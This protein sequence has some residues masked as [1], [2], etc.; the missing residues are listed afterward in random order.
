MRRLSSAWRQQGLKIALVPTMGFFHQGHLSLM[1][2]ARSLGE[3]VVVSLFVNPTQFGPGEDLDKYPRDIGRDMMLAEEH[4]V[5]CVFM[6]DASDIYYPK[7]QTWIEVTEVSKGLCGASRPGHFRG[8]ATVVAKLFNIVQPDLAI[9]GEKDYQQLQVIRTMVRDLNMPVE[10]KSHPTVREPD[11]LAMSS[12]NSYL[13][14]EDR[15]TALCLFNAIQL[16]RK[17]AAAGER[18]RETIV[19]KLSELI[20][21][22]KGAKVDYIFLGDPE[23]LVEDEHISLPALLALAVYVNQ[24][25]LIDNCIITADLKMV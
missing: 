23:T 19:K 25:R 15:E 18:H 24:T 13:S 7:H 9:F 12:R 22:H 4:G 2:M 20:H 14:P 16:A 21:S 1:D 10:I 8:V 5:D 11:G 6:P 17:M 3:K